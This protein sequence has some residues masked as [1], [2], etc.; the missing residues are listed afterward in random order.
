MLDEYFTQ[1]CAHYRAQGIDV[2]YVNASGNLANLRRD[3]EHWEVR[4]IEA[5]FHQKMWD[6]Q[7]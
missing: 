1:H 4:L 3:D 7:G 5:A 2:I 6:G